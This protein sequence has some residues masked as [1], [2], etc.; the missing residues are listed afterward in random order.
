MLSV[1][2]NLVDGGR[3]EE[4]ELLIGIDPR[5]AQSARDRIAADLRVAKPKCRPRRG[6]IV[7]I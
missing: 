6:W 2:E 4:G 5:D 7:H 3:V 1:S